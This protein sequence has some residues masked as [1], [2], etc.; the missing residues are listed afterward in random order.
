MAPVT[1]WRQGLRDWIFLGIYT[2]DAG[3]LTIGCAARLVDRRRK[4]GGFSH[5]DQNKQTIR[6]NLQA[7][8]PPARLDINRR[9]PGS[10]LC[11]LRSPRLCVTGD[12]DPEQGARWWQKKEYQ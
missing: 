4:L 5:G 10:G 2:A 12:A 11:D 1:D 7:V 6:T 9:Q 3:R 8:N